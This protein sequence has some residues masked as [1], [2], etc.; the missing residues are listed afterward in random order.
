MDLKTFENRIRYSNFSFFGFAL[1]NRSP[2]QCNGFDSIGRILCSKSRGMLSGKSVSV[3]S[4]LACAFLLGAFGSFFSDLSDS[5]R[6]S[7]CAFF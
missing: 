3:S 4:G 7:E 2:I 5:Y 1:H 6:F